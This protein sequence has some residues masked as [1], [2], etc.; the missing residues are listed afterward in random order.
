M[1]IILF[2]VRC[3]KMRVDFKESMT[4][5]A[6]SD[7]KARETESKQG[8]PRLILAPLGD[9]GL[10]TTLD[11]VDGTSGTARLACHEEDTGL[12]CEEG[13]GRLARFACY[14][15]HCGCGEGGVSHFFL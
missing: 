1:Y 2:C 13:V 11:G 3:Q 10:E 5:I 8:S 7:G 14:V 15:F 4:G 12:L 9:L 6:S